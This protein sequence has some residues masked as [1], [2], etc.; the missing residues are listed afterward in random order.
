MPDVRKCRKEQERLV[1]QREGT[2]GAGCFCA[3]AEFS[4]TSGVLATRL[5]T[6]GPPEQPSYQQGSPTG[7]SA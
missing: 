5:A 3:E 6:P 7:P 4:S 2:F 1:S